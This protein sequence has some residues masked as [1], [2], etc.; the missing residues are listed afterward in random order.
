MGWWEV[1]GSGK[2]GAKPDGLVILRNKSQ[3]LLSI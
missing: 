2:G 3:T 1:S